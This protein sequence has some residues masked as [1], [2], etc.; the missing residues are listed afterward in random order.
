[1]NN[2]NFNNYNKHNRFSFFNILFIVLFAVA[3]LSL[4]FSNFKVNTSIFDKLSNNKETS[5][6]ENID[7]SD[8][9]LIKQLYCQYDKS[10]RF[11]KAQGG[12]R[13]YIPTNNG[14]INYNIVHSISES[15]NFDI[16]RIGQAYAFDDNLDNEYPITPQGAEWDMALML[17]GRDD[18][19]G[20]SAH[21]DEIYTSLTMFIDGKQVD[22]TTINELTSFT[23][24]TILENSIG[25]DPN[26]H[27]TQALYHYKEYIINSKGITLNQKVQWL[28]DYTLGSS[29]MAMMPPMK[30]LT[31]TF[32]TNIDYNPIPTLNNYGS[33]LK[34]TKAIVYGDNLSFTMSI[35]KYPNL[36][37]G[38]RFLI[39]DNSGGAYNK[40]YFVICNGASVSNGDIWET[41]TCYQIRNS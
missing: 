40:M 41:T 10:I 28:N 13:L 36:T 35:P 30:T 15:A 27:T 2:K 8:E 23:E 38:N 7:E 34:A 20:G 18:F 1:M 24:I 3:L 14:Y 25:Y 4:V 16:W 37:G 39:T 6:N 9:T 11:E 26:D 33:Y 31:N 29:Y 5:N 17:S 12:L 32:Y 21:G 19:I 22:I